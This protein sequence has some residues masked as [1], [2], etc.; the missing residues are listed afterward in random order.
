MRAQNSGARSLRVECI[1]ICFCFPLFII[2]HSL[3]INILIF[4]VLIIKA[5][6]SMIFCRRKCIYYTRIL[7]IDQIIIMRYRI[8]AE[9]KCLVQR[10]SVRILLNE[11]LFAFAE[12]I[13]LINRQLDYVLTFHV[14]YD[15][16]APQ[17]FNIGNLMFIR[18]DEWWMVYFWIP[19]LFSIR[20][21]QRK[22]DIDHSAHLVF[23][24]ATRINTFY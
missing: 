5:K 9:L 23:P 7:T 14:K 2:K 11:W 17:N 1:N 15:N 21:T 4:Q 12:W 18:I 8:Y 10:G 22:T 20:M 19:G 16:L 24:V 3:I 13:W 6:V